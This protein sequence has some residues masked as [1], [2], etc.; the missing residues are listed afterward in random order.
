MCDAPSPSSTSSP[1][2][3]PAVDN[4]NGLT[5]GTLVGAVLGS[6]AGGALLLGFALWLLARKKRAKQA[7]AAAEFTRSEQDQDS[8]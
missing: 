4:E 6:L 3:S 7:R 5:T 1:S 2:P 8:S